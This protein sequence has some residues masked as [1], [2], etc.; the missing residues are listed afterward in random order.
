M[1]RIGK[2]PIEIPKGVEVKVNGNLVNIKGPLGQITQKIPEN[3]E[4]KI[5]DN[6]IKVERKNDLKQT[7]ASHGL[8]RSLL[9]NHI[10]GVTQGWTKRL[11]LVGVGYRANLKGN[12]LVLSLGYSHDVNYDLPEGIKAK[13]DQQTKIELTGIDKQ[14]VGQVAAVIRSF[15]PPEPYKGKGIRYEDEEIIRKAGKAGKGK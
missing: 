4:V 10:I 15:R 2:L 8:V 13:V 6:K 11:L 12:T 3:I 5:E 9:K 1:S 14:K 7:K